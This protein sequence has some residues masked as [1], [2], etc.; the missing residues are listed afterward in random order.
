MGLQKLSWTALEPQK[1]RKT[2]GFSNVFANVGFQ[3]VRAFDGPLGP[4]LAPLGPIWSQ[5]D[6]QNG[7]P[8]RSKSTLK[9]LKIGSLRVEKQKKCKT[10]IK[11]RLGVQVG[12]RLI[13]DGFTMVRDGPKMAQAVPREPQDG[14]SWAKMDQ[15]CSKCA[16]TKPQN[17]PRWLKDVL[18]YGPLKVS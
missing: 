17:L 8:N 9:S 15:D 2:N 4:I 18:R 3:H 11:F 10:V 13:Q 1:P 5:N 14:T 7:S 6:L 16:P 12:P